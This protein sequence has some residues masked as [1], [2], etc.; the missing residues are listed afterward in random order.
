MHGGRPTAPSGSTPTARSTPTPT[1]ARPTATTS[2]PARP[3]PRRS[4]GPR[5]RA[6][7]RSCTR[8]D[9]EPSPEV[10]DDEYPLLLTTGRTVYHFHTRTKTGRA[11]EL[12]AAAPDVVGRAQRARTPSALGRRRGRPGARRVRRAAR[13]RRRARVSGIRAGRGLR[14]R[15]TT[16]T[17]TSTEPARRRRAGRQRADDHRLGPGLQAAD[18][19]GRRGRARRLAAARG[20]PS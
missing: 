8:A 4:T 11:P 3:A 18:L 17:G 16:A 14:A 20:G 13:S 1:T 10:T 2:S 15:S 19:Q 5:S 9:Y 12:E 6:G 7:A